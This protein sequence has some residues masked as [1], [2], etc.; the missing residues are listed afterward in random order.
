M[1]TL[2]LTEYVRTDALIPQS[3][4]CWGSAMAALSRRDVKHRL[5]VRGGVGDGAKVGN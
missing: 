5:I 3:T 1:V 4:H 2:G